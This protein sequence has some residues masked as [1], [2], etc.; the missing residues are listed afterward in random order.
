MDVAVTGASGFVGA[1]L[2][3]SLLARGDRVR[4]LVRDPGAAICRL[5]AVRVFQGDLADPG[6]VPAEFV[7]GADVLYHCAAE[8]RD[9][10]RM[11]AT[12]I[13]G[14]RALAR[15]AAGRIGRWVHLS[16]ASVYGAVR[17]GRIVE[18]SPLRPDSVYGGT[19]VESEAIVQAAA[20]AGGFGFVI[21][22]PS[23]VFG[24]G[25]PGVSLFKLFAMIDRGL[26]CFVGQPNAVMNYVHVDNAAAALVLAGTRDAAAGRTYNVS[27]QMPIEDLAAIVAGEIGVRRPARRLPEVPLRIVAGALGWVPGMPLA[28]RN[29]DALTQRASYASDRIREE[30]G[31][32]PAVSLEAGLRELARNWKQSR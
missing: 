32:E 14:T 15:L 23:N 13:E 16:S 11:N 10:R 19:K 4:A 30:L 3:R 5:P 29:L 8:I 22:R 6:R 24:I 2:V 12:N 18:G 21:L 31:Y 28:H 7:A 17:S 20:A 27:D 26:F 9:E 25:M 1:T